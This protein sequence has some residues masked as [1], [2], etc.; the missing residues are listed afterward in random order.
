MCGIALILCK[1]KDAQ[2]LSTLMQSI[3]DSLSFR[4]PDENEAIRVNR[5]IGLVHTRLS[6]N[7]LGDGRQPFVHRRPFDP[8]VVN[9]FS[10]VNGEIYNYPQLKIYYGLKNLMT[11]S[12][13]EVVGHGYFRDGLRSLN[14]LDGMFASIIVDPE[15][16]EIFAVRDAFGEKPLY[17]YQDN[18]LLI[19]SSS[20]RSIINSLNHVRFSVEAK[21]VM[22]F[23]RY[24]FVPDGTL[25]REIK[26]VPKG[27][28]LQFDFLGNLKERH[29]LE[30]VCNN[31]SSLD[32]ELDYAVSRVSLSDVPISVALSGGLDSGLILHY[33]RR[34][35]VNLLPMTIDNETGSSEWKQAALTS[36]Q[37]GYDAQKLAIP[38]DY[39]Q[40]YLNNQ[41]ASLDSPFG[42]ITS[43]A[44]YF[45]CEQA[46][47]LG[48][49]VIL[50][51]HGLDEFFFGYRWVNN[52]ALGVVAEQ[53][54][55]SDAQVKNNG[56]PDLFSN[57]PYTLSTHDAFVTLLSPI[58][59][60]CYENF[61]SD[62]DRARSPLEVSR[63]I[64]DLYL[65]QNGLL[66]LDNISMKIGIEARSPFV[67]RRLVRLAHDLFQSLSMFERIKVLK[68][69]KAKV[70]EH[71][72]AHV[73]SMHHTLV[74]KT[75]FSP[76]VNT[77]HQLIKEKYLREWDHHFLSGNVNGGLSRKMAENLPLNA[78]RVLFYLDSHISS[79]G[80]SIA[81]EFA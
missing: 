57:A 74:P 66:Q 33:M 62:K 25:F 56:V 71:V 68:S 11:R 35:N 31:K 54:L 80:S 6:I 43:A 26:E 49:K 46:K 8:K 29:H 59:G 22:A 36:E 12:D 47:R 78:M 77:W 55:N 14:R 3:K 37:N 7:G 4:G 64:S 17:L 41:Y 2:R 45:L 30:K 5:H 67:S 76:D 28:V 10:V 34:H 13:C 16:S 40:E 21:N 39:F 58:L 70:R 52:V 42:D 81:E 32:E 44:Y 73:P 18:T 51:G 15:N 69:S 53:D 63:T 9:G 24:Q 20:I 61:V 23:L 75:G 72:S 79:F 38:R 50:F 48:C 1:N 60:R 27:E 65:K 19:L